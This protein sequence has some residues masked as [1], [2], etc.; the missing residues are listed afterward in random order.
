MRNVENE[1]KIVNEKIE[2]NIRNFS[3]EY[4]EECTQDILSV[5]R[6]FTEH[7]AMYIVHG[8]K[9][10]VEDNYYAEIKNLFP[11]QKPAGCH[12]SELYDLHRLLQMVASHYV[13]SLESCPRLMR[14]YIDYLFI[15]KK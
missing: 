11:K 5:L 10:N 7:C 4:E 13:P 14:K 1:L 6:T 15:I 8:G 2:R 3:S 12:Y 9:Y